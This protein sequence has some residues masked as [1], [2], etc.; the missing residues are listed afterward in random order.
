M[1]SKPPTKL[2][3][4]LRMPRPH[5]DADPVGTYQSVPPGYHL[6][7]QADGQATYVLSP[8]RV[9]AAGG[10]RGRGARG[11]WRRVQGTLKVE[12]THAGAGAVRLPRR[13]RATLIPQE[14]DLLLVSDRLPGEPHRLERVP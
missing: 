2:G 6:D 12:L 10:W 13:A 3:P 1:T 7:L 4:P 14:R 5:S 9:D 11:T 8:A